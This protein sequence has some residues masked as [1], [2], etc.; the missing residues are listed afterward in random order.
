MQ[1]N[2]KLLGLTPA[3]YSSLIQ[4]S[5][6]V[7]LAEMA[8]GTLLCSPH[9]APRARLEHHPPTITLQTMQEHLPMEPA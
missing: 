6:P 1:F 3:D 2:R 4:T 5:A 7:I 9:T 8:L